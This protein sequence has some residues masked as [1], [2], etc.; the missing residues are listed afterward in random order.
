MWFFSYLNQKVEPIATP[1][2]PHDR[3]VRNSMQYFPSYLTGELI[4]K[5]LFDTFSPTSRPI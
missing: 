4:N 2:S 5:K 3:K 1:T